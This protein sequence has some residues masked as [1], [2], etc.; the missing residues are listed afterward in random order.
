MPSVIRDEV[1]PETRSNGN[2]RV[3]TT[4][5]RRRTCWSSGLA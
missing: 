3:A 4:T 1:V 5:A 2:E